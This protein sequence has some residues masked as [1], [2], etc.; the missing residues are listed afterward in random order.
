MVRDAYG[1]KA[2]TEFSRV[3]FHRCIKDF[4]RHHGCEPCSFLGYCEDRVLLSG[5]RRVRAL[6]TDS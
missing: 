1:K 3:K 2:V 5:L 4:L 6:C